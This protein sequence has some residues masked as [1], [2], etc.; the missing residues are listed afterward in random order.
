MMLAEA[1]WPPAERPR[2]FVCGPSPLV[3]TVA[4]ELAAVGHDPAL[5]KTE[6]FGPTGGAQP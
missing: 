5:I 4:S 6:R 1:T 3:E 2:I